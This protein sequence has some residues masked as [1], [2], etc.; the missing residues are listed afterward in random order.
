MENGSPLAHWKATEGSTAKELT[1]LRRLHHAHGLR[2]HRT[3]STQ[4]DQCVINSRIG[5]KDDEIIK[6]RLKPAIS[7]LSIALVSNK[8]P[9]VLLH[10]RRPAFSS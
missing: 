6:I 7:T 8:Q 5:S 10:P 2:F 4:Y 1:D 3:S 9:F